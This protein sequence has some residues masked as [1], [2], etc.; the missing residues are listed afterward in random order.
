M[1]IVQ[2][3]KTKWGFKMYRGHAC[4][5]K[6]SGAY[7]FSSPCLCEGLQLEMSLSAS[8]TTSIRLH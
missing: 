3:V 5:V 8:T 7:V 4:A 2:P 1:K 6:I